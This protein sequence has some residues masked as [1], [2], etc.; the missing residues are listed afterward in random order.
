MGT[1][2]RLTYHVVFSTR[3][4]RKLIQREFREQLYE[5]IGGIIR[6]HKGQ[7]IEI[8]GME[9]HLHLLVDFSPARSISE[10]IRDV[11]ANASRWA[12]EYSTT[13]Y[14]FEW[15]KGYSAFTVSHSQRESVR[16]YIR[17]QPAHHR[18]KTFREEYMEFLKQH[19][20]KFE[21]RYLFETEHQG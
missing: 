18:V 20:I 2:N 10:T 4:R 14:G 15:Q 11:K 19:D 3:Y 8:G 21:S 13:G 1:Y 7:L 17:N 5:Y 12:K 6:F 9:D 16:R